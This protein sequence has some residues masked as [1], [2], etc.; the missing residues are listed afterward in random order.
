MQASP[1][2]KSHSKLLRLTSTSELSEFTSILELA[3]NNPQKYNIRCKDILVDQIGDPYVISQYFEN[4]AEGDRVKLKGKI[5][6]E[7]IMLQTGIERFDTLTEEHLV[8]NIQ[9]IYA[10]NYITK[11]KM[12]PV[13]YRIVIYIQPLKGVVL[14]KKETEQLIPGDSRVK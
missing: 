1:V 14:D 9:I 11:D 12:N 8:G 7:V 3:Y 6:G 10:E 4:P 2:I 5:Y 13:Y